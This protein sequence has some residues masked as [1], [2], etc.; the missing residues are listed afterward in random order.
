K[1][2]LSLPDVTCTVCWKTQPNMIKHDP[3]FGLT[4]QRNIKWQCICVR[5]LTIIDWHFI[6]RCWLAVINRWQRCLIRQS[7]M[8]DD[9]FVRNKWHQEPECTIR[10]PSV[11]NTPANRVAAW[12]TK[13]L[14]H[15]RCC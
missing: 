4:V 9:P 14:S 5:L 2:G 15:R 13:S 1:H 6:S 8:C 11:V 3:G 10:P 12:T 7:I